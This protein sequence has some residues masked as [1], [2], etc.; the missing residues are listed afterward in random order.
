M[1][2]Q[3]SFHAALENC[4]ER[5]R[6]LE[7]GHEVWA[8]YKVGTRAGSHRTRRALRACASPRAY[9]VETVN[10]SREAAHSAPCVRRATNVRTGTVFSRVPLDVLEQATRLYETRMHLCPEVLFEKCVVLVEKIGLGDKCRLL[11]G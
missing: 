4:L 5:P 9:D 6:L 11:E 2:K 7:E 8:V 10:K 3:T 1:L